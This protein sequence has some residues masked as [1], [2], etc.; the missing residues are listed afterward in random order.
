MRT[1]LIL[2]F[3]FSLALVSCNEDSNDLPTEDF[4]E[5]TVNGQTYRN[6]ANIGPGFSGQGGCDDKSYLTAL[7]G[8][9][10]VTALFL[11]VYIKHYGNDTDFKASQPGKYGMTAI[12]GYDVSALVEGCNLGLGISYAD[13]QQAENQA[14]LQP[15]SIH[16]VTAIKEIE[17]TSVHIGY[18]VSGSF[19]C[20]FMNSQGQIIP[21]TGKYQTKV[22]ALK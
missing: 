9:I 6:V 20:S 5:C 14:T 8:Q 12:A 17:R 15:G 16:N 21:V 7:L 2:L 10:D 3:C 22:Y 13:K 19:S 1:F 4:I 18:S 11:N